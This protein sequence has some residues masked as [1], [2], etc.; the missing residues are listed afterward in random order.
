M[1]FQSKLPGVGTT[2]FTV[3]SKMANE[4][5]AINLS[6]GFPD[7]DV[8]G[9][10]ITLI[11]KHMRAGKNQYAPMQ[12]VLEL[13][14]LIAQKTR[15]M[16]GHTCD[17][18]TD[19]T[20]TAG[21][22]EALFAAIACSVGAGDEVIIFEPA[23]DSYTPAITLSGGVPVPLKMTFP[24]YSIDWDEVKDAITPRTRMIILNSPHNPYGGR[25][26]RG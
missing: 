18:A 2:I 21:A 24:D 7:F 4:H 12:G 25:T 10:I 20:V 6:Q 22:T 11:E 1:N 5:G 26:M 19:I 3:M 9:D 13:R 14:E 15:E 17:P 23:Y 16:Y 8:N